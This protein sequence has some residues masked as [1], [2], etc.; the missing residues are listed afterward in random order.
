M[1]TVYVQVCGAAAAAAIPP[2]LSEGIVAGARRRPGA[3]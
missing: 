2:C 1:D 3:L